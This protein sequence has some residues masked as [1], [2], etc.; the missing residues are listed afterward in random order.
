MKARQFMLRSCLCAVMALSAACSGGSS[1]S[2]SS[3]SS[4]GSSGGSSSTPS[5]GIV[6]QSGLALSNVDTN[7]PVYLSLTGLDANAQYS[8]SV[9]A[10]DGST[11]SPEGGFIATTDEDG[12]IPTSTLLQDLSTTSSGS[13]LVLWSTTPEPRLAAQEGEYEIVVTNSEGEEV[14]TDAF[15]VIDDDKAFCADSDG[16]GR[17]SFTPSENVYVRIEKGDD[18]DLADGTY[19]CYVVSDLNAVIEN[20]DAVS[21]TSVS[22][23]VA[24][25]VGT[26]SLGTFS[27]GQYDLVCDI[28]GDGVYDAGSDLLARPG[29]FRPCFT[30]QDANSGNDIVGQVCSDHLGNYRD[31]FDP[32]ADDADIRDVWAW[33]SPSER[34]LVEHATGVRKYV[35][36]HQDSWTDGDDLND[37]T[38]D[39][40]TSS[41]EV[42]SVQGFCTNEA[43][44]LVWPRARMRQGCFDCIIDVNAN[45]TYDKGTDFVDNIDNSGDNATCGM[46]VTDSACEDT[47][48]VI[49]SHSDGD[50][51]DATAI[52]LEGTFG[53]QPVSANV[54]VTSGTQSTT[55]N[56][57]VSD[58]GSDGTVSFSAVIPLFNGENQ[59]TVTSITG[60]AEAC[61]QT[62]VITS[63]SSASSSELFR[64][65][66]TWDGDTDMDLHLV[67]PDGAYSNGG[68]GTDDCN[69]SNCK[70]GLDASTENS[71][72]WGDTGEDDDPKLDVDCIACGNGIENIWLNGIPEDGDYDVYV[73]AYSGTETAVNVSVSIRGATVGT[74]N[75][76]EMS[77]G[78]ATDSCFV[79]TI[80][81]SGG[82]SGSG[83][84][85]PSGTKAATF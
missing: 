39:S 78:A 71:I 55:I 25:G 33:I 23:T 18:G 84:F 69:Y 13:S 41:F 32:N 58:A 5:G 73:D 75:C 57:D 68:G 30:I 6:D 79:G 15:S 66:L 34:S 19:A 85:T 35:V 14:V 44:W 12:A 43:P 9:T 70:V 63:S 11:L 24:S 20:G 59:L 81:W 83:T 64:A 31:V 17:A 67:R 65:Q 56:I 10:P 72:D 48:V 62:I 76:G 49:S 8:V 29:R 46:R 54:T 21:G 51:V 52:T 38:G 36:E 42:D 1:S 45:G 26:A 2:G 37:V 27:S 3:S 16:S 40:A 28:D 50:T 74:V 4:G 82:D 60:D 61:A 47:A 80:T 77:S 53:T 22:V 7:D